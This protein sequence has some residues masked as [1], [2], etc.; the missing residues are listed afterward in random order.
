[1]DLWLYILLLVVFL[2]LRVPVAFA[3]IA[4]SMLYFYSHNL[5]AGYA[6]ARPGR[7][8]GPIQLAA[9]GTGPDNGFT[10]TAQYGG[11]GRWGDY[12]NGEIIP[13]TNRVWLATQYIPNS[14]DGNAN[15]GNAIFQLRLP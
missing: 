11:A 13:G 10:G 3:M 12:S 5:S 9:A 15:W 2:L 14:G 8:F 4:S 7:D 1:M 6:T